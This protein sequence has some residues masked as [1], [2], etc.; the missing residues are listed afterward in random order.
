MVLLAVVALAL[1]FGVLFIGRVGAARRKELMRQWPAV[2]FAGAALLFLA[3]GSVRTALIF[4]VLASASW[5]VT[6]V[7]EKR[8]RP[9]APPA[10]APADAEARSILGVGPTATDAEIRSAYRAKMAQAHPDRGGKHAEAARLT[11]ARD[12]LL[13]RPR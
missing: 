5:V 13:K 6:S 3:R 2:L 11:A 12:R 8:A 1:I 10:A 9:S 7:L 4:I